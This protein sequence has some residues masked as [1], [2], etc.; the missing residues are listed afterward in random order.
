MQSQLSFS[1]VWNGYATDKEALAARNAK[2][3]ELRKAGRIIKCWTL[4]NQ[5]RK[6]AGFG[7]PD[8]RSCN[9]YMISN[10]GA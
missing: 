2:A 5:T 10:Y 3:R 6:Y 1:T 9:V 4:R 8:G 7:Q